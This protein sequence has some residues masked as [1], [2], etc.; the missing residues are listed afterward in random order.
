[1]VQND[2]NGDNDCFSTDFSIHRAISSQTLWQTRYTEILN[3]NFRMCCHVT[4]LIDRFRPT[5]TYPHTHTQ[6]MTNETHLIYFVFFR[7]Y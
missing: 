4:D 6:T 2:A 1:M 7:I 5:A 3:D